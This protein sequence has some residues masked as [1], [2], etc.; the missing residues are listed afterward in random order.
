M[1]ILKQDQ[2]NNSRHKI[3]KWKLKKTTGDNNDAKI[4]YDRSE[5][6]TISKVSQKRSI[7]NRD[8]DLKANAQGGNLLQ[9]KSLN[10]LTQEMWNKRGYN[11]L[12]MPHRM[13]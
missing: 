3:F 10:T 6:N 13:P 9:R 5:Y 12:Q 11:G 2:K 8:K 7:Q 4:H 1:R